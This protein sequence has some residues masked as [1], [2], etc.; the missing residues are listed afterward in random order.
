MGARAC[1]RIKETSSVQ[2]YKKR[3]N[4]VAGMLSYGPNVKIVWFCREDFF[5]LE[6][7]EKE[8]K[9]QKGGSW[10]EKIGRQV[11]YL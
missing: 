8:E 2:R 3:C 5:L 1:G 10:E 9:S 7:E 4:R 11:G 6:G